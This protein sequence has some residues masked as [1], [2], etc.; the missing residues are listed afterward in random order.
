MNRHLRYCCAAAVLLLALLT[1]LHLASAGVVYNVSANTSAIEGTIGTFDLEFNPGGVASLAATATVT[2][3]VTDGTGLSLNATDGD[4][5]G[6]LSPGPLAINNT[7]GL[8]DLL[9]NI[10]FGTNIAF[11]VALSGT[12]VTAPDSSLPGSS[13]G[14]SFYDSSFNPLLTTDPAG[15]VVT[16]N[17]NSDGSTSPVTFLSN[18]S[19]GAPIGSA[20]L[21]TPAAV[22]EPS[23][24]VLLASGLLGIGVYARRNRKSPGRSSAIQGVLRAP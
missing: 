18:Y 15:T 12:G 19:G 9:E 4:V 22:P 5:T 21:Q 10:T 6:T 7:F 1:D 8:N 24:L 20:V 14:L 2:D 11:T 23:S 17:L 13:F 16:V 3:F